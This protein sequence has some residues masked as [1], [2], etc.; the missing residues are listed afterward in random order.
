MPNNEVGADTAQQQDALGQ[1][2]GLRLHHA[3]RPEQIAI[4]VTIFVAWLFAG[5]LGHDP[6]KPDEAQT[7]GI[8]YEMVQTGGWVV[9]KLAGEPFLENPPL[10]YLVAASF[11]KFFAPLLPLHDGA[12]L[13]TGF[14]LLLT[15]TFTALTGR[16]LYGRGYGVVSAVILIGCLGLLVHA[17]QIITD[18]ALLAAVAIALYG[19]A[20]ASRGRLRGGFWLGTGIGIGFFAQGVFAP[21]VFA[22]VAIALPICFR[23]W[24]AR[25]YFLCLAVAAIAAAPWLALWPYALHRQA[26]MLFNV[27]LE[28][29]AINLFDLKPSALAYYLSILPWY[30]WPALPLALWSLW[31]G[32]AAGWGNA[33]VHLPVVSF[34][35]MLLTLSVAATASEIYALPLLVPLALLASTSA[36]SLRRGA[37]NALDWFGIMTFGLAAALLWLGWFALLSGHPMRLAARLARY[38]PGFRGE[39][40]LFPF[41]IS[42][43]FSVLW[44]AL[45]ARI[46]PSN[47]RAFINWAGG[48][49][50]AWVMAMTLWLPFIDTV[51]SY[52]PTF[53]SL[54]QALP[55][56]WQ[57][58]ASQGLGE[59]QRALLHYFAGIVTRRAERA[60]DASG[61][62]L[63]LIQTTASDKNSPGEAWEKIWEGTRPGDRHERYRL[64]RLVEVRTAV[65]RPAR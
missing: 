32:R 3:L 43:V 16:E 50:L 33:G 7:F 46:G 15:L 13:A 6:W 52:R 4:V 30:A 38:A 31:H 5:L 28:T 12:R 36:N 29:N 49:T 20:L 44:V 61:C 8:V 53:W 57:C 1:H 60:G 11:A 14:F 26:P 42:I 63:L 23:S 39:F 34:I 9:P 35:V 21:L 17:H 48:I 2:D 47:R 64:Y 58:L 45:V 56:D 24:R 51:K 25:P 54:K 65:N 40:S 55:A 18:A 62:E 22:L 10:Y 59:S 41:A 27:W 19:L 37:A